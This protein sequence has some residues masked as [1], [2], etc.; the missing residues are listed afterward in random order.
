MIS[1]LLGEIRTVWYFQS[2]LQILSIVLLSGIVNPW[3]FLPTLPMAL[4]FIV[5]RRYYLRTSR[6]IRRLEATSEL[7]LRP[8][9][10]LYQFYF[11]KAIFTPALVFHHS[12]AD[13]R[14]CIFFETVKRIN[15]KGL[16]KCAY[17]RYLQSISFVVQKCQIWVLIT[18]FL[19]NDT[20]WDWKQLLPISQ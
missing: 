19:Q 6:D 14:Y 17:E 10:L 18:L 15:A 1:P 8:P 11:S 12:I 5:L 7:Q 13:K 3:V 20:I 16:S 4:V 2:A 9:H